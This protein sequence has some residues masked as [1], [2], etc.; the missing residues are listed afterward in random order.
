MIRSIKYMVLIFNLLLSSLAYTGELK[1]N[2]GEP[3]SPAPRYVYIPD[4]F[5]VASYIGI[6]PIE[7]PTKEQRQAGL[8]LEAASRKKTRLEIERAIALKSK[9]R[10]NARYLAKACCLY[11][12]DNVTEF[13]WTICTADNCCCECYEYPRIYNTKK[14]IES[15]KKKY[16]DF[17]DTTTVAPRQEILN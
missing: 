12:S 3:K 5:S 10:K 16:P 6:E 7:I 1:S 14:Y 11:N 15:F 4:H 8:I 9:Q 17:Y 13:K 2:T